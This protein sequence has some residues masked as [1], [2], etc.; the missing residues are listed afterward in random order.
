MKY[1]KSDA[2]ILIAV[3]AEY[4]QVVE[5]N[6]LS[7]LINFLSHEHMPYDNQRKSDGMSSSL[8]TLEVACPSHLR[9]R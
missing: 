8:D 3:G 2:V 5:W 6:G 1:V 7:S 9:W 4:L